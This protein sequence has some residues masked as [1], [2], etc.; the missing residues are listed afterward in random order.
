MDTFVLLVV[1]GIGTT[2]QRNTKDLTRAIFVF[3][4]I[5]LSVHI[6]PRF[7][8]AARDSAIRLLIS[9]SQPPVFVI[10]DPK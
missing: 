1:H 6:F 9:A 7:T 5:P 2:F 10:K 8:I 4:V 3:L